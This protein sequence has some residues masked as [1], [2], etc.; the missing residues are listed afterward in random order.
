MYLQR[1]IGAYD[2]SHNGVFWWEYKAPSKSKG[3]VRIGM[4]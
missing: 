3:T 4:G 1:A 2:F